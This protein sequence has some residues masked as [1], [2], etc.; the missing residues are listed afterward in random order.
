MDR[1]G[2]IATCRDELYTAVLADTLDGFGHF[3]QCLHP[4]LAALQEGSTIAGF[5]RVGLYMPI[6][7]DDET[8]NV[9]EHEIRLIDD[10]AR[11]DL[12]VLICNGNLGI[13]PWGELLSTRAQVLGASGCVTDG[14]VRDVRRIRQMNFPVFCAGRNPVDTKHRGKM[15]WADAPGR[16]AGVRI[17][18]GDLLVA[19]DDGIVVVPAP[20]I[21]TV[22]AKALDKVRAE[23]TVR[24]ELEAGASLVD[25]FD[26]HGI[27]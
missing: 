15:M 3:D 17:A 19:D 11:H 1:D 22:V 5:A 7:H 27:L 6:F 26:R 8:V 9:Y 23:N 12:P 14:C 13:A 2:L 20:L 10:L 21:E 24:E 18:S 4:G 16:I 25:V